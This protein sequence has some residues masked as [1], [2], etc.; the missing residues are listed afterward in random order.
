MAPPPPQ[1]LP[2]TRTALRVLRGADAGGFG[3]S[4]GLSLGVHAAA[5]GCA[6]LVAYGARPGVRAAAS[7]EAELLLAEAESAEAWQAEPVTPPDEPLELPEEPEAEVV[8]VD[9][10][11]EP[12][13]FDPQP[14]LEPVHQDPSVFE[15][16]GSTPLARVESVPPPP[17]AAPA[18]SAPAAAAS[19][20]APRG[21][22]RPLALLDAPAPVY[23][24]LSRRLQEEGTVTLLIE[25]DARGRVLS[26]RIVAGSGHARLDQAALAAVRDWT[27]TPALEDGEPVAASLEHRVSFRLGAAR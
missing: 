10:P 22:D 26:V 25:V 4:F 19:A 16:L 13:P 5:L 8:P 2:A 6:F 23:P 11:L 21:E 7:S 18:A 15:R 3:R 9:D 24:R 20:P 14:T 17:A 1:P 12:E 27:F